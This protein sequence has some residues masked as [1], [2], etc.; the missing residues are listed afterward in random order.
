MVVK[1]LVGY[2]CSMHVE[3][4]TLLQNLQLTGHVSDFTDFI[5]QSDELFSIFSSC[6]FYVFIL[7]LNQL[8]QLTYLSVKD[9][10]S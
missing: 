9:F 5:L 10:S 3:I 2:V 7:N 1:V 4:S 8:I 6:S